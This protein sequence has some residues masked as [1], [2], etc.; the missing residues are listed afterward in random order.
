MVFTV[1]SSVY[2]KPCYHFRILTLSLRLLQFYTFLESQFDVFVYF[3]ILPAPPPP[4][5]TH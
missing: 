5:D 4:R 2:L 3:L 1:V